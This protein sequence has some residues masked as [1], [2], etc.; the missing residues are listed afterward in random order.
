VAN[1]PVRKAGL[2]RDIVETIAL[3]PDQIIRSTYTKECSV[4]ME[5]NEQVLISE[6]NKILR[7]TLGKQ[8]EQE[9]PDATEQEPDFSDQPEALVDHDKADYQEADIVRLLLNYGDHDLFF[10]EK[11]NDRETHMVTES[12]KSFIIH[13]VTQDN[14]KFDN[15]DYEI[16]FRDFETLVHGDL[17]Y[18][19]QFF[20]NHP[21]ENIRKITADLLSVRYPLAQWNERGVSV[22]EEVD[23]LKHAVISAV[24]SIKIKHISKLIKTN[25]EAIKT[26]ADKG[27]EIDHLL[28]LQKQL[29]EIKSQLS[30]YLSIVVL[31]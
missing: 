7:K 21:N 11:I 28:I 17:K 23:R 29:D 16:I 9:L 18:D 8:Q 14:I 19:Q 15:N 26:A 25:R 24:Y 10:E 5:I 30:E 27:D 13:E 22:K 31:K 4:L 20:V 12:V 3:I 1:D 6:L 2:I